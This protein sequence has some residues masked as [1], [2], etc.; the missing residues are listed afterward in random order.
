M[1]HD[2]DF[3]VI[4]V[5]G[6]HAGCEAAAAAARTGARTALITHKRSTIGEMSCNPAIGGLGKGHLVREIDALDGLMGRM[7]D[8][9]GIQY[10][11]LNRSKG[12]AVWGPRA[13]IDRKL[14]R[15]AMQAELSDYPNL[16]IIED[17]VED[18]IEHEGKVSGVVGQSGQSWSAPAVVITTGTFLRGIIHRG[19]ERIEAGRLGEKPS[20]G[21]AERLYAMKLP[22]G[23][24]KTGTPARLDGD[25]IDWDSLE[26]QPADDE[27]VPFSFMSDRID[28]PQISCGI[29]F[30]NERTHE[31]IAENL[32]K[33]AVYSGAIAGR[34]PR[35]CPSIED[36]VHRF[37]DKTRHQIF[38]EPEGLDDSTVYPNGISTSLPTDVQEAFIKTIPGLENVR[39]IQPGYAIEY[40]YVDPRALTRGLGVKVLPGLFLAGQIN[41]T[42]GYEE[43]GAQGLVAGLNAARFSRDLDPVIFDRA[44][45]YIGVMIDDLTTVGVT[46]PYRMFTSRAEYRLALRAD[47]AD[48]RLTE[49]GISVGL[50]GEARASMFHVKQE[51]LATGRELLQTSSLTPNE[52]SQK[53]WKVNQDGQRRSAWDFLAYPTINMTDVETAFPSIEKL[54]PD[55]KVQLGIEAIYAG[56]I[57]RQSADVTALRRDE[58]LSI[59]EDMDFGS[60]GGLSNEVRSK[61]ETVR[62]STIGQASRIEGVTPGALVAL[63]AYVKRSKKMKATG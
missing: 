63:L 39:I 61:L 24:L 16:S 34:G 8:K 7:A 55:I 27:P 13:Q 21:L 22:M 17:G 44:Q 28:V 42:T 1:P 38:L 12:P 4:V 43:A 59:P 35:Y 33:S 25:T 58:A 6:G 5:G 31:I 19:E 2:F 23:R 26:K 41:G 48:Q 49:T 18:L 20:I 57:E 46:E 3:D 36:K 32:N 14:Y 52:A 51:K 54:D 9:A 60:V 15:Q 50:V 56:Y 10:R 40:D 30:T 37:A 62:P 45:A 11:L 47:N 29:T 53:G